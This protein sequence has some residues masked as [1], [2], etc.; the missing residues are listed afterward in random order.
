LNLIPTS[1]FTIINSHD[2]DTGRL[3]LQERFRAAINFSYF[4]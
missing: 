2:R 3:H 1:R 4:F